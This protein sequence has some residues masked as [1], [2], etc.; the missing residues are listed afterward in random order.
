MV[1]NWLV[2]QESKKLEAYLSLALFSTEMDA[3]QYVEMLQQFHYLKHHYVIKE[4]ASEKV[5]LDMCLDGYPLD[6][7]YEDGKEN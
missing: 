5:M 4:V 6:E 1:M 2:A 7:R 3:K